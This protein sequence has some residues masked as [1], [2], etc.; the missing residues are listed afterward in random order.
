MVWGRLFMMHDFE[1]TPLLKAFRLTSCIV[2]LK[3]DKH[4]KWKKDP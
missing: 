3:C 1:R 4:E 2:A